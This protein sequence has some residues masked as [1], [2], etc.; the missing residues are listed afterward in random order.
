MLIVHRTEKLSSFFCSFFTPLREVKN[1]L[2]APPVTPPRPP[3]PSR[4]SAGRLICILIC[5][6]ICMHRVFKFPRSAAVAARAM[7]SETGPDRRIPHCHQLRKKKK[8]QKNR[9]LRNIRRNGLS[10]EPGLH[11]GL[12]SKLVFCGELTVSKQR[13]KQ[14]VFAFE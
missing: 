14:E 2:E 3:P 5:M 7:A 1:R 11:F 6:L 4:H 8:Q 12:D 10:H 9:A 13:P